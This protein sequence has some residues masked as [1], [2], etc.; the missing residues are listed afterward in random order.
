VWQ[1]TPKLLASS[2]HNNKSRNA[3]IDVERLHQRL[4]HH[5]INAIHT[6]YENYAWQETTA[7]LNNEKVCNTCKIATSRAHNRNDH[8]S[9]SPCAAGAMACM[10]IIP[11]KSN[12][13]LTTGAA[14]SSYLLLVDRY[15]PRSFIGGLPE[16][17]SA[18]VID[19]VEEFQ[20]PTIIMIKFIIILSALTPTASE[21]RVVTTLLPTILL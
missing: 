16:N 6:V 7:I 13:G 12:T 14:F 19:V 4:G 8:P 3:L 5:K 15:L 21:S 1:E 2:S 17:L 9:T 18:A 10:E 20:T 11:V